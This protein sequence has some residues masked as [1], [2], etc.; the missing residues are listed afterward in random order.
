M[1]PV[2]LID[3]VLFCFQPFQSYYFRWSAVNIIKVFVFYRFP[4]MDIDVTVPSSC[5]LNLSHSAIEPIPA[6]L[7]TPDDQ[8]NSS[9]GSL[10]P[11]EDTANT[12]EQWL[13]EPSPTSCG[14][15]L[16]NQLKLSVGCDESED[17]EEE[18]NGSA[19][20][21]DDLAEKMKWQMQCGPSRSEF[22]DNFD[23][24]LTAERIK[25]IIQGEGLVFRPVEEEAFV[26]EVFSEK[27]PKICN[28]YLFGDVIG[29]GSYAKVKEVVEEFSLVRRAVKIVKTNRLRKIPN[30]QEN[31]EREIRILRKVQH[32]NIIRLIEVFRN[33]EKR[34]LYM[35]ME[36]CMG[37]V[38]QLLD[39]APLKRLPEPEVHS[40][41]RQLIRG[42]EYLHSIGIV[43]K[44]IKPGNL[45]LSPEFVLKISDFGVAEEL[46]LFANNDICHTVQGTPQFQA[47]ELVSGNTTSYSGFKADVWSSGVS[48]YNMISGEYPFQGE[49]IMRL[50]D[51]IA[52]QPLV[53][54][55]TIV[56]DELL[57]ELLIGLLQ[58]NAV[59]R[60]CLDQI[61]T[62]DWYRKTFFSDAP[63]STFP[64]NRKHS[65]FRPLSVSKALEQMYGAG[66]PQDRLVASND[67]DD[68]MQSVAG[69]NSSS[70]EE[71]RKT[72]SYP[73]RNRSLLSCL[74]PNRSP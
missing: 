49:V 3:T 7:I 53:M 28:G 46:P 47:P 27:K 4:R 67:M 38:Q 5:D 74:L 69:A 26:D 55:T 35:V 45:L 54:P 44:D 20:N 63:F 11:A 32:E 30:G 8:S 2:N 1:I 12:P 9:K 18:Q 13:V 70:R 60:W 59:S 64:E 41:F 56:L 43:H 31:V 17:D 68:T 29:E 62:S 24:T 36:F 22:S 37:S 42:L 61:K 14:V 6:H 73:R 71:S 25:A 39:A 72:P 40:Y 34:K 21:A 65:V 57:Q 16:N 23:V 52:K 51:N 10:S 19:D 50:F 66:I 48:L 15:L 33:D 58:K